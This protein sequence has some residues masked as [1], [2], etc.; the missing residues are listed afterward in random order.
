MLA[1]TNRPRHTQDRKNNSYIDKE[2]AIAELSRLSREVA[3]FE[4]LNKR[5]DAYFAEFRSIL[6]DV[7]KNGLITKELYDKIKD[8]DYSPRVFLNHAFDFG[9]NDVSVRDYGLSGDQVKAI[10]E[11]S[12]DDTIMDSRFLLAAYAASASSRILKNRANKALFNVALDNTNSE[13]VKPQDPSGD[14]A[15]G[16]E[17]V[18]LY[19]NGE[20]SKFQLRTDLKREWDGANRLL[21]FVP[22]TTKAISYIT[23]SALLKL[24]AT[25]ANPLFIVRNLPRDFG[26]ILFFTDVYDNQNIYFG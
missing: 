9:D 13:W 14:A 21:E 19:E 1:E 7:Y 20:Q 5:A 8:F 22:K 26:H 11:G 18:Y 10:R 23:G 3:N 4:E 17:T 24:L 12:A 2:G 25:R 6:D 15:T 16:F